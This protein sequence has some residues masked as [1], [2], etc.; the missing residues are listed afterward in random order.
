MSTGIKA[1]S[2][3]PSGELLVNGDT[4]M[5]F[6]GDSIR[7]PKGS[8]IE[9]PNPAQEGMLRFNTETKKFEGYTGSANGWVEL[10]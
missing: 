1:T 5:V 4:V 2:G 10:H 8:T 9:R 6:R 7:I 3:E